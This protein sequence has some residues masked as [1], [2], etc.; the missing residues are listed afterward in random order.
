M[1]YTLYN[2]YFYMHQKL[3]LQMIT[4]LT[5]EF[6]NTFFNSTG[7]LCT[8]SFNTLNNYDV[9]QPRP[10]FAEIYGST[11]TLL[12]IAG[13]QLPLNP[14]NIHYYIYIYLYRPVCVR[15]SLS[16]FIFQN[17]SKKSRNFTVLFHCPCTFLKHFFQTKFVRASQHSQSLHKTV[18][19]INCKAYL[20]SNIHT[21]TKPFKPLIL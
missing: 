14:S 13:L 6:R 20:N 8:L 10:T 16:L 7:P 3:L 19:L 11:F 2:F 1:T 12:P 4:K 9:M 5:T 17:N 15:V 18:D 21:C